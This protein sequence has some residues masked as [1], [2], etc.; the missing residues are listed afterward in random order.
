MTTLPFLELNNM[1]RKTKYEIER[2][3]LLK[4]GEKL[5]YDFEI[6]TVDEMRQEGITH[7]KLG[8]YTK[9]LTGIYEEKKEEQRIN[10]LLK[11][12]TVYESERERIISE[13]NKI[14]V[15]VDIPAIKELRL[16]G[17]NGKE[18]LKRTLSLKKVSYKGVEVQKNND[19][20]DYYK[21]II[22]NAFDY[23]KNVNFIS[24]NRTYSLLY[25]L[26]NYR[27]KYGDKVVAEALLE[28]PPN[29]IEDL[30]KT[31]PSDE[32][33]IEYTTRFFTTLE[34]LTEQDKEELDKVYES[35]NGDWQETNIN[36]EEL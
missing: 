21:V 33:F 25:K 31:Y 23:I 32:A 24:D 34:F 28:V 18:L 12:K 16:S 2:E 14:G 30:L 20:L 7:S 27:F 26:E 19:G 3:K 9:K 36:F 6:P 29:I 10:K 4:L 22:D 1:P 5:G 11:S 17:I 35:D 15:T 13:A 8:S